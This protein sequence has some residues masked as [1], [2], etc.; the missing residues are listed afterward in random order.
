MANI[1]KYHHG[2]L[3]ETLIREAWKQ[4]EQGGAIAL[5]LSKLAKTI[6]VSQPAVYRHFSSKQALTI[7]VAQKGLEQL[8]EALQSATQGTEENALACIEAITRA[9]VEFALNNSE[10]TRL[11][12][13]M[14]ERTSNLA[15][16]TASKTASVPLYHIAELA[17][18]A[19]RLR[20]R[21]VAQ[22]VRILWSTIHGLSMLLMDE[23][24]PDVTRSSAELSRYI[25]ATAQTLHTGLFAA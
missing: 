10:I 3:R 17:Q 21:D 6:G 1:E 11:M 20:N 25:E 13:S 4:I 22:T 9:Y 23:Q 2:H 12:F 19:D 14:R 5:N 8:A 15:L 7:S 24:M 16:Q 18:Q